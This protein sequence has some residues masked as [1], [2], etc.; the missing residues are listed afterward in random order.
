MPAKQT[1]HSFRLFAT[2]VPIG[3]AIG[4]AATAGVATGSRIGS[5]GAD[6]SGAA[7]NAMGVAKTPADG[8]CAGP[9]AGGGASGHM[10]NAPVPV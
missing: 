5:G 8:N 3:N 6:G 1:T 4:N 10:W 9:G 2:N 7:D